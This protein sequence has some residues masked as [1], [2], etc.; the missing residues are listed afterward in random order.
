V[1]DTHAHLDALDDP[2]AAVAR[3][4]DAGVTRIVTI[5]TD[6]ISW[7]NLLP[8]VEE[9]DGVYGA[10]GIHPHAATSEF[11]VDALERLVAHPKIVAVGE[12]GLDYFRDYAPREAQSKIFI[13]QL[14]LAKRAQLP[15]VIHNRA[16]DDD[17]VS[18]LRQWFDGTVVL[19]CFSSLA[20]LPEAVEHGWYVSF[21]G[22]VTYANAGDLRDAARAVP[23]E[24]IL[25][26]TDCPYLAPQPVRGQ[27]N[28]PA[29]VVHTVA[30]LAEARGEEPEAIAVQIDANATAAFGLPSW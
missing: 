8:I 13:Y 16:A 10:A 23:A 2:A 26:E 28:E 1:I 25:A 14:A 18:I 12:I 6:P 29:Y 17:T 3:A 22:N 9:H 4:R 20:L 7:A 24:L 21:A 11:D 15:I 5:G 27:T 30:A 19:H